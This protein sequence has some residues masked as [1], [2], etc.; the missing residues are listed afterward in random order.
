MTITI[1]YFD[2]CPSWQI[3]VARVREVTGADPA[4]ELIE[5]PEDAER[6][7][8]RG[9]PTILV[10]GVDPF[11]QGTLPIGMACRLYRTEDGVQG[12][13]SVAQLRAAL[14]GG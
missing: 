1:V 8:F 6:R 14:K 2:G 7:Q 11:A 13:P 3:A 12:S 10:D 5:S 4:L 9:S